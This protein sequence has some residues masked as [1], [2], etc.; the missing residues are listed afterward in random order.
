VMKKMLALVL[1][2]IVFHNCINAQNVVPINKQWIF[3]P[4]AT[5]ERTDKKLKVMIIGTH[6]IRHKDLA[7]GQPIVGEVAMSLDFREVLSKIE[8]D[9]LVYAAAYDNIKY[10]KIELQELQGEYLNWHAT[11]IREND[12]V[13]SDNTLSAMEKIRTML[14]DTYRKNGY[15]IYQFNFSPG[16]HQYKD[17]GSSTFKTYQFEKL[18]PLSPLYVKVYEKGEIKNLLSQF[19]STSKSSPGYLTI[20][21]KDDNNKD[22]KTN[23]GVVSGG[24]HKMTDEEIRIDISYRKTI[25]ESYTIDGDRLYAMGSGFYPAALEKYKLAQASYYSATV[26]R[27]IDEINSWSVL[28]QSLAAGVIGFNNL[29]EKID[30]KGKTRKFYWLL[31]YTGL[32]GKYDKITNKAVQQPYDMTLAWSTHLLL[33]SVEGRIGYYQSPVYEY[34]VEGPGN[35]QFLNKVQVQNSSL[36]VGISGGLNIPLNP[37]VFYAIYG[38]DARAVTTE[39][40]MLTD[41]FSF[42][43]V[44]GKES[45]PVFGTRTT[46]GL[47]FKIPKTKI[48]IGAQYNLHSINGET[49]QS[50]LVR[51]SG[52]STGVYYMRRTTD[53]RYQFQNWGVSL[54]FN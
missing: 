8:S 51:Y 31:T 7:A 48:G 39:R 12:L 10:D 25:A 19:N 40:K 34:D 13:P 5:G 49:G 2:S 4:Y 37:F 6:L 54:V 24:T 42:D 45:L 53:D 41:R 26:Q 35:G 16:S 30:P 43:D 36:G 15:K 46:L 9:E 11:D 32:G 23:S 14:I 27:R 50:K 47:I 1:F 17:M 21:S 33:I 3:F 29:A 20:T 52:N 38:L 28:G 44:N 22:K 18:S